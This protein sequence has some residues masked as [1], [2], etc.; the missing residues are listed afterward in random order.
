[1]TARKKA[2]PAR[3]VQAVK[4]RADPS[5]ASKPASKPKAKGKYPAPAAP[6]QQAPRELPYTSP[7]LLSVR[8][9][10]G[11]LDLSERKVYYLLAKGELSKIKIDN[12][13]RIRRSVVEAYI[14]AREA[15]SAQASA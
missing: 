6:V 7:L 5:P 4:A 10:A 14:D 13:T 8:D 3:T 15:I 11:L 2:Q 12:A 9:A 1:M